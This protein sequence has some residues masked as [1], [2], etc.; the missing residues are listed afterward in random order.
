MDAYRLSGFVVDKIQFRQLSNDR[1]AVIVIEFT[2]LTALNK[3]QGAAD[4]FGGNVVEK[5]ALARGS[6]R[7]Y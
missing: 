4:I 2:Q 1:I 3:P 6:E 5:Y 7:T